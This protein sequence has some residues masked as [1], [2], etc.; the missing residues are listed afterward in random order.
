MSTNPSKPTK[1]Q[2]K[3]DNDILK[4]VSFGK[5]LIP[6][7]I[8]LAVVIYM[9]YNNWKPGL[10]DHVEWS[11]KTL[12]FL[13]LACVAVGFRHFFYMWRLKKLSDNFFTWQK[14]FELILIWEFSSAVTPT[15][16]GGAAI[17]L[18]TIPQ[19]KLSTGKTA[20]IVVFTIIVDTLFHVTAIALAV[21][22]F[23]AIVYW[24]NG[25]SGS[26][27]SYWSGAF[28]FA[29]PLIA[30][31][32]ALLYIGVFH[33]PQTIKN[34]LFKLCSLPLLKKMQ[35][36]A[37]S[38]GNDIVEASKE[39]TQKSTRYFIEVYLVTAG[40]WI[41]RFSVLI[42]LVFAFFNFKDII[43]NPSNPINGASQIV[44]TLFL[45][46]R[47][48]TLF[49]IMEVSPSPGGAGLVDDAFQKFT[50]DVLPFG[51]YGAFVI[52][53]GQ[54]WRFLTYYIYLLIGAVIVPNWINNVIKNRTAKTS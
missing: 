14:C 43:H 17:A 41:A 25:V 16:V 21:L 2:S 38:F 53:I 23:G 33:Y 8:S 37:V 48:V 20:A 39:L 51:K 22:F 26:D 18:F 15:S 40:A 9:L 45:Y 29:L 10:F 32:G 5:V 3:I 47:Q 11:W 27:P 34:F 44:Q 54:L 28:M 31:W 7:G 6:I 49:V 35:R 30:G 24:P 4:T 36:N 19:E 52:V 12:I 50:S 42:F 13:I 1:Y 46:A